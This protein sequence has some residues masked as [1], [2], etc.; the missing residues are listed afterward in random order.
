MGFYGEEQDPQVVD[1]GKLD[2]TRGQF[3]NFCRQHQNFRMTA[4]AEGI[5]EAPEQRASDATH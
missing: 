3:I 2:A 5:L 1:L 4:V